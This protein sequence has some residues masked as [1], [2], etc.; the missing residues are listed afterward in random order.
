M[1]AAVEHPERPA[2]VAIVLRGRR[3]SGKGGFAHVFGQLFASHFVHVSHAQHLSGHFNA[4]LQDA[5]VVFADEAFLAGDRHAGGAL[6]MLITE[7]RIPIERKGHDVVFADNRIHLLIA[8]ND[9]R[10]V[11]AGADERRFAVLDVAG[12]HAQDH[13]YFAALTDQLQHGGLEA[14]LYDLRAWDYSDVNLRQPPMTAALF[15]QKLHSMDPASRWWFDKL[16]TG[17]LISTPYPRMK[18]GLWRFGATSFTRSTE[19]P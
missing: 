18:L 9:Q 10:I 3:G 17:R 13:R 11:P 5:V 4:H 6:K 19:P 8:S 16:W 15:D 1:A 12:E 7:P 2:E 14:M